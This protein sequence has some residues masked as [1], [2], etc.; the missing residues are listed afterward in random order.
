MTL[1]EAV[2]VADMKLAEAGKLF[3]DI[4]ELTQTGLEVEEEI[5]LIV[6]GLGYLA[7]AITLAGSYVVATP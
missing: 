7:L 3:H 5:M 6:Q 4:A 1:L 2:E